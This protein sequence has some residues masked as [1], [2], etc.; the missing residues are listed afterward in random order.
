M[1]R[2]RDAGPGRR[3]RQQPRRRQ[4][5]RGRQVL[6]LT[7]AEIDRVLGPRAALFKRFYDVTEQG[8]WEGR[9][10][11]NRLAHKALADDESERELALCRA[12][13]FRAREERVRPGRDDKVLADW[14]GLMIAAMANAGLVFERPD[15]IERARDAF[16]FV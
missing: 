5:A 6:R 14:N 11:L 8:N 4:R 7:E 3:L 16:A 1:G 15:W 13:L 12:L 10:I 9:N 2:P